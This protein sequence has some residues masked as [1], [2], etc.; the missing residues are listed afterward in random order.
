M[1]LTNTV[2]TPPSIPV[3]CPVV[4]MGGSISA[5]RTVPSLLSANVRVAE[6]GAISGVCEGTTI[7]AGVDRRNKLWIAYAVLAL[8]AATVAVFTCL[9][10]S[11]P[12]NR[13]EAATEPSLPHS[14][15]PSLSVTSLVEHTRNSIDGRVVE[16]WVFQKD[17]PDPDFEK[18]LFAEARKAGIL[19][20][21]LTYRSSTKPGPHIY[22]P[23]GDRED[24]WTLSVFDGKFDVHKFYDG[25]GDAPGWTIVFEKHLLTGSKAA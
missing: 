2:A 13:S 1:L 17:P 23:F 14:L 21:D 19:E 22:L 11:Q 12:D 18:R 15:F 8:V 10:P 25:R 5:A 7:L 6:W 24:G 9:K 20:R 3:A 4:L 16:S